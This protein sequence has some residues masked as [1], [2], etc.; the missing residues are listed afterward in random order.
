MTNSSWS[1][2]SMSSSASP[3]RL[4]I[5]SFQGGVFV[6]QTTTTSCSGQ[7]QWCTSSHAAYWMMSRFLSTSFSTSANLIFQV[8][9]L[10]LRLTRLII[11]RLGTK[12]PG[13]CRGVLV[14][15]AMRDS[16]PRPSP[17]KGAALPTELI[18]LETRG[19]V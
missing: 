8:F 19:V 4:A 5:S 1:E 18:A 15:C 14:W 10:N 16:N 12:H 9:K 11:S 13:I 3:N 2:A 7:S 6:A 17:C